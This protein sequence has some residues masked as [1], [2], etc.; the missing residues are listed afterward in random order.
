MV[1]TVRGL[2]CVLPNIVDDPIFLKFFPFLLLRL[3]LAFLPLLWTDF[4]FVCKYRVIFLTA[5]TL[6]QYENEKKP[7]SELGALLDE[8]LQ[9][10]H[11]SVLSWFSWQVVSRP[12]EQIPK[13]SASWAILRFLLQNV[14][15]LFTASKSH[16]KPFLVQNEIKRFTVSP[17]FMDSRSISSNPLMKCLLAI[18]ELEE[19]SSEDTFLTCICLVHDL[20][21]Q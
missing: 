2:L 9:K 1:S 4:S 5:P 18:S 8:V 11:K 13:C 16:F 6:V 12:L 15:R 7:M 20:Y 3:L 17:C 14:T 10:K 21:E 19:K